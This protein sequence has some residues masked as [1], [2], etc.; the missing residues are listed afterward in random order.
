MARTKGLS[1][2]W[3]QHLH[4][5]DGETNEEY[6]KRKDD[7]KA[8]VRNSK[9]IFEVLTNLIDLKLQECETSKDN[10]YTKAAWPY[11]QAD[12]LGQTRA[13]NYV[14]ELLTNG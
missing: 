4:R 9:D 13:Y 10:D 12:R 2:A 1:T 6:R 3:T 8:Y 14:K 11:L 7:F 5:Q